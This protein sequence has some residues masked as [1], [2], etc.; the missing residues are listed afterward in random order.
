MAKDRDVLKKILKK[1]NQLVTRAVAEELVDQIARDSVYS[2]DEKDYLQARRDNEDLFFSQG[3]EKF[4]GRLL[5]NLPL[6][7]QRQAAA[8]AHAA[9]LNGAIMGIVGLEGEIGIDKTDAIFDLIVANGYTDSY[10]F[11]LTFLYNGERLTEEAKVS[12]KSKIAGRR[13]MI[14]HTAWAEKK[15]DA[16]LAT[17]F[18]GAF[19]GKT[20]DM[21]LAEK[22]IDAVVLDGQYSDQEK[23]TVTNLFRNAEI[24]DDVK[25]FIQ[26]GIKNRFVFDGSVVD[27][28]KAAIVLKET[29]THWQIVDGVVDGQE[30]DIIIE[31]ADIGSGMSYA[32][33]Q[34]VLFCMETFNV[35]ALAEEK[36][37]AAL[38]KD[39]EKKAEKVAKVTAKITEAAEKEE[40][41][42]DEESA[43]TITPSKTLMAAY[44]ELKTNNGQITARQADDFVAAIFKDGKYTKHEQA[45]MR[46][47]RQEGVFTAAATREILSG[48]RSFIAEKNFAK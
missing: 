35:T 42:T 10:K 38:A 33:E 6:H 47:L 12:L 23:L 27:A 26:D 18:D 25:G 20:V 21:A 40:T 24:S 19:L 7:F 48:L 8:E 2:A 45:T 36:F 29:D 1:N 16:A 43:V 14:A 41:V 39:A 32:K 17:L 46:L 15:A 44:N 34:T 13:A 5:S 22:V 30:A 9:K 11:T 3:T 31:L 28:F 4:L 37:I